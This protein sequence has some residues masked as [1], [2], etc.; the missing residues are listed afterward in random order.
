MNRVFYSIW[1][2]D[3]F[4]HTPKADITIVSSSNHISSIWTHL[5]RGEFLVH[6]FNPSLIGLVHEVYQFDGVVFQSHTNERRAARHQLHGHWQRGAADF[7]SLD[8]LVQLKISDEKVIA[9]SD[10]A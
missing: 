1:G 9:L 3:L 10:E 5:H 2:Q 8:D 6:G 4:V 7:N